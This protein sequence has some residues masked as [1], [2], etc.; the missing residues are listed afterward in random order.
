MERRTLRRIYLRLP[1]ELAPL[2]GADYGTTRMP[3][4]YDAIQRNLE[5]RSERLIH[6]EFETLRAQRKPEG[7]VNRSSPD[8]DNADLS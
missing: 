2:P 6:A 3:H 1:D 8:H 5:E 4:D 7:V